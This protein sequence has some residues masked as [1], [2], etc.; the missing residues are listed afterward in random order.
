MPFVPQSIS[1]PQSRQIGLRRWMTM[2]YPIDSIA[3]S[4]YGVGRN[5]RHKRRHIFLITQGVTVGKSSSSDD[6]RQRRRHC[7]IR[8]RQGRVS[9]SY[10][11]KLPY[12]TW[13]WHTM[14]PTIVTCC[15]A[16]PLPPHCWS[17][18]PPTPVSMPHFSLTFNIPAAQRRVV[19]PVPSLVWLLDL[20]AY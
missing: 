5:G 14:L 11:T 20:F 18:R 2:A 13:I 12:W 4:R 19:T 3:L 16:S 1:Q 9:D 17:S 10:R 15:D 6:D 8:Q 7:P